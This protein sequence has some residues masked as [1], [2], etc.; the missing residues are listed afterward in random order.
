MESVKEF[1]RKNE[2]FLNTVFEELCKIP[3][4]SGLEDERAQYCKNLL[5][6]FGLFSYIDEAKNVICPINCDNSDDITVVVA[7]TDTVFPDRDT[8]PYSEKDGVVYCPGAGDDT[9]C[10]V[11]LL[12]AAK[13][14]CEENAEFPSGVLIVCNSC[15]EGLGNL[16]GTRAVMD[17]Y[18]GR[19]KQFLSLDGK[20]KNIADRCVGSHRY[21]VC[22]NTTGGHSW[23]NFGNK[24]AIKE[25]ADIINK[26][27]ALPLPEHGNDKTSYNVGI[28]SGGTSINTIAQSAEFLCEYRSESVVCLNEMRAAFENIFNAAGCDEVS[29]QYTMIAERPCA[30]EGMEEKIKTLSLVC[31]NIITQV[32]GIVPSYH[33]SSTDCNIPLSLGVPSLCIGTYSGG[34]EHTREEWV[35]KESLLYG[36]EIAIRVIES[37]AGVEK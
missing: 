27:Y 14:F 10:L 7:H 15:E 23:G 30:A 9:A 28:I 29:V 21:R 25:A 37:L 6:S 33:S 3:A 5:D 31:E 35:E 8:M 11:T 19:V 4:P 17:A 32:T 16:K 1:V 26:I 13:Y 18:K 24:N 22:V 36:T 2:N 34:G 20:I 12:M